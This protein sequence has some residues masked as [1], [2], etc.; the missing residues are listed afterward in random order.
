MRRIS[1]LFELDCI[2]GNEKASRF[3]GKKF[4]RPKSFA[5]VR[6]IVVSSNKKVC[7][8]VFIKIV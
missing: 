6:S 2:S 3:D 7:A 4:V 1:H 5:P 8:V